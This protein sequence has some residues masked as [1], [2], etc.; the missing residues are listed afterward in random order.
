MTRWL[1]CILAALLTLLLAYAARTAE[2]WGCPPYEGEEGCTLALD[3]G[4]P[5]PWSGRLYSPNAHEIIRRQVAEDERRIRDLRSALEAARTQR[6]DCLGAIH[7]VIAQ[8][9][10]TAAR[11][12]D[13]LADDAHAPAMPVWPRMLAVGALTGATVGGA[14][15]VGAGWGATS[16]AGGVALVS[17]VALDVLVTWAIRR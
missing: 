9:D 10:E 16:A 13:A 7:P 3:K 15:A 4:T 5:A 2:P 1:I 8:V 14:R 12:E 17:G 11:V 6:D